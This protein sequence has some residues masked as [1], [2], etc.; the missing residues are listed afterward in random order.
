MRFY[1]AFSLSVTVLLMS[2]PFTFTG[3]DA[4]V[5]REP[6][7]VA[8]GFTTNLYDVQPHLAKNYDKDDNSGFQQASFQPGDAPAGNIIEAVRDAGYDYIELNT[9][10]I[11]LLTDEAFEEAFAM[12]REAGLPVPVTNVFVPGHIKLVGPD[13]DFNQQNEYL[14]VAYER[15]QRLGVEYIVFG[16]AGARRIPEGFSR[17]EAWN[18]IVEFSHRAAE[19]ASEFNLMILIEHLRQEETN[20]INTVAEGFELVKE[21]DHPQFQIM[22][23][24]YH[25][26]Y[27]MEDPDI[28]LEV[29]DYLHHLHMANP[30]GRVFPLE[31]DE[32]P[33]YVEFFQNLRD[34]GY[35]K[36]ISIEARFEDFYSESQ[37]SIEMMHEAFDPDYELS[38][39]Y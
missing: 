21:V 5:E 14:Q 24:F 26:A 7:P 19:K 34:T 38:S 28:V 27:E 37:R 4:Q 29:A 35:D 32:H 30:E 22:I 8:V 2:I 13:T 36:R 20:F 12:I 6:A 31:W 17:E 25:L 23:D 9:A 18:Q 11:A 33:F 15:L 10:E 39:V 3:C 1:P 16:S